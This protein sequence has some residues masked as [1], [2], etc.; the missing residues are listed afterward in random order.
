MRENRIIVQLL[1]YS[2]GAHAL[3]EGAL[4]LMTF[5][6]APPAAHLE[7]PT[8]VNWSTIRSPSPS[9]C[10]PMISSGPP[11]CRRRHPCP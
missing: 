8:Q 5:A 9:A 7:G 10:C 3:L 6:D 4:S 11:R 2:A 1:P